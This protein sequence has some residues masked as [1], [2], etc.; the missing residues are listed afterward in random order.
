VEERL[1]DLV[2]HSPATVFE[3]CVIIVMNPHRW[4]SDPFMAKV[5]ILIVCSSSVG[6]LPSLCSV[7]P[8]DVCT[9]LDPSS[10]TVQ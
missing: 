3:G 5:C 6:L 7:L 4:Y 9:L 1:L 2:Q 10:P 8:V